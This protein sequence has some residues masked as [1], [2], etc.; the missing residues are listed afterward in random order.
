M[1]YIVPNPFLAFPI[2]TYT[3]LSYEV[4]VGA[5]TNTWTS[6][7]NAFGSE[8]VAEL[9]ADFHGWLIDTARPWFGAAVFTFEWSRS[10][11]SV[12]ASLSCNVAFSLTLM[13]GDNVIGLADC[14]AALDTTAANTASGTWAPPT[15]DLGPLWCIQSSGAASRVLSTGGALRSS[16]GHQAGKVTG[17]CNSVDL[18]RLSDV[19][20]SAAGWTATATYVDTAGIST[21]LSWNPPSYAPG[22]LQVWIVT[23]DVVVGV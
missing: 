14:I 22:G 21:A 19:L 17:L 2:G 8:T 10:H 23:L 13:G 5:G 18:V 12:W 9:A 4:T 11:G 16:Q 15:L 20:S 1:V 3:A 7:T 6:T